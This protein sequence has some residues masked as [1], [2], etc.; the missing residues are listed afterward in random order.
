[1]DDSPAKIL[2]AVDGGPQAQAVARMAANLATKMGSELHVVHVGFVPAM[3]HPEMQGYRSRFEAVRQETQQ[4]LDEEVGRVEAVCARV[5]R[6]HLRM[7][8]PDVEIVELAE[9]LGAGLIVVGSRGLGGLRRTLMGSVSDSVVRHAHCPVLV[10]RE[11][12]LS[13]SP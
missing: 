13:S 5:A 8:R 4:I 6:S 7:G 11:G 9:D 10:V 1:M 12:A 2:A 3:Y